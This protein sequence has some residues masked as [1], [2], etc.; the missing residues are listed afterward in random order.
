MKH[1]HS[2]PAKKRLVLLGGG[3]SHLAVLM[4]LARSPVP[5]LDVT[6]ISRD[7]DTPYSGA[8]PAFI[9]GHAR[10]DDFLIDLR[11]LAQMAGA[12]LIQTNVE[13]FD[14]VNHVLHCAGRPVVHFDILS[15]NL[16]SK[17][18]SSAIPGADR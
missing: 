6:L 11:P 9:T 5:G 7:V 1:R 2:A 10:E 4:S 17:P 15:L 16:G 18:D 13:E 12:R 8:L 3:H 14:L